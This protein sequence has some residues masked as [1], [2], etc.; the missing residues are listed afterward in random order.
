MDRAGVV[1]AIVQIKPLRSPRAIGQWRQEKR[2]KEFSVA[3]L[4][5]LKDTLKI[6]EKAIFVLLGA[7]TVST[8]CVCKLYA[9]TKNFMGQKSRPLYKQFTSNNSELLQIR[10][11][12][13]GKQQVFWNAGGKRFQNDIDINYWGTA[14][15]GSL[16]SP[17]LRKTVQDLGL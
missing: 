6:S 17:R 12:Y 1:M 3:G 7:Q 4:V 15:V 5:T 13:P 2:S 8:S 9:V 16:L 10:K 14:A 11:H